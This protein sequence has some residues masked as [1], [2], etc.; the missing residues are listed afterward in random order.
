MASEHNPS[1]IW[2]DRSREQYEN[3]VDV[4]ISGYPTA[5]VPVPGHTP[6]AFL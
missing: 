2:E 6:P 4:S 1:C 5:F 3:I